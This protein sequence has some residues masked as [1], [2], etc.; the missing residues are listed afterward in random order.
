MKK[1]AYLALGLSALIASCSAETDAEPRARKSH[2]D[3]PPIAYGDWGDPFEGLPT[4]AAQLERVCSTAGDDLVRDLFCGPEQLSIGS[5]LDLQ[6]ALRLGPSGIAGVSGAALTGHTTSL[7]ARSVSAINPRVIFYRLGVMPANIE[8]VALSFN[9]G[10]Q[11]AEIAVL[12]R[13]GSEFRFYLL[14]F[15]QPCNQAPGGCT[16]GDLLT[17]AAET[18]WQDVTLYDE[19]S[20]ANTV[21]DCATCHQPGGP[22]T[23]KLLRMQEFDSPWTHWFY[24]NTD[25]GKALVD[26]YTAAKGDESVAGLPREEVEYSAPGGLQL[27]V[28]SRNHDQPNVFDSAVIEREVRDSAAQSGGNQPFDN[29]IPGTSPT[30]RAAYERAQRGESIP[31]PYH[32]VKVTDPAKLERLTLA[33]Q[34][35]LAGDLAREELPDL[36]DVFPDD[37]ARLAAMGVM[38]EPGLSGEAV[39]IE[40]C[41]MCHNDRLDPSLSRARF[42]ADLQGLS[43]TEKD[44]AIARL[45]LPANDVH[46]MP[47]ARLRALSKQARARAIDALRR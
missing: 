10:D 24:K 8:F 40:A 18:D 6:A 25:G 19:P 43:R 4:G 29:S 15:Q 27:L 3:A 28:G 47:P 33:Y 11:F 9:R 20:L 37:P 16:P 30:W 13:R 45:S 22:N 35:Y 39:L 41:S 34:A 7:S 17:E 38:T 21:L 2:T 23:P 1:Q 14:H 31:L 36:R 12:D 5:A 26:D 32:D 46:A 44:L 42:R